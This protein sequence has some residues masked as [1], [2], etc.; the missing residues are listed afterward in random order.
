[1]ER[2]LL[3]MSSCLRF[4]YCTLFALVLLAGAGYGSARLVAGGLREA[5]RT[6]AAEARRHQEISYKED[7]LQQVL[8]VKGRIIPEVIAGRRSLAGAV[9]AFRAAYEANPE[10]LPAQGLDDV[11]LAGNVLNWVRSELQARDSMNET[12][13]SR[14]EAEMQDLREQATRTPRPAESLTH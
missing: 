1:M 6:L 14:L 3:A 2:L 5:L 9:A 13:L 8:A 12:V 11:R 7:A 10:C 4:C